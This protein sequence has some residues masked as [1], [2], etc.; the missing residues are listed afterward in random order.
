MIYFI[1]GLFLGSFLNNVAY[2]LANEEEFPFY[3][4]RCPKC[5][6]ILNWYELIP[7]LSFIIQKGKCRGCREKISLRYPLTE[8]ISG[9]FTFFLAQK[10][11]IIQLTPLYLN[12]TSIIHFLYF[13]IFISV[14]FILA[15]Y[16]LD[17]TYIHEKVLIIG[18]IFWIIFQIIFFKFIPAPNIDF[19][20]GLNYIFF[21]KENFLS[22]I[23]L[24]FLSTIFIL[25]IFTFS[26]GKGMGIGDAKIFFLLGLYLKGGDLILIF[27]I[28]TFL[29]SFYGLLKLLKNKKF[30]QELPFVPFIFLSTLIVMFFGDFLYNEFLK[31]MLK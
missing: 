1:L 21:I 26:L 3:R 17:T 31:F 18:I 20:D 11:K 28:S 10:I 7:L 8:L 9:F 15:L 30:F 5:K 22:K 13:L 14:L 29:G 16:D 2:R 23:Y 19:S 4:S 24:A 25:A 12:F 27:I 6:K